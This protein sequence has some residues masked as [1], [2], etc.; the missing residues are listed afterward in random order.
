LKA[1]VRDALAVYRNLTGS[2]VLTTNRGIA[3]WGRIVDD[4]VG[5]AA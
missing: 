5:A 1:D 3:S 2:I 4:Q